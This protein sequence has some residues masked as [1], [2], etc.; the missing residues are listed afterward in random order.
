MRETKIICTLGPASEK[1]ETLLAMAKAGMNIARF[2]MSHGTHAE[3]LEKLNA[4]RQINAEK[5]VFIEN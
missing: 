3:H 1:K 2:N 4:V 5:E